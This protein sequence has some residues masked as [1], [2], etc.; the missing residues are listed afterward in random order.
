MTLN[1]EDEDFFNVED[2]FDFEVEDFEDEYE[3]ESWIPRRRNATNSTRPV[4]P[5][6]RNSTHGNRHRRNE[7]RTIVPKRNSTNWTR[8]RRN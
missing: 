8:P 5:W 6:K 2:E 4:N 1:V 7:T 3:V